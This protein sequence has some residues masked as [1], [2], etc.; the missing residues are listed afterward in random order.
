MFQLEEKR[1]NQNLFN[2][3]IHFFPSWK[4]ISS[5]ISLV[6]Q[7]S[8]GENTVPSL[9]STI[10]INF[11][12]FTWKILISSLYLQHLSWI[13]VIL[14]PPSETISM[15]LITLAKE[16]G[17]QLMR[18]IFFG[19]ISITMKIFINMIPS[20]NWLLTRINLIGQWK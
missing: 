18:E 17:F 2:F 3:L 6:H 13:R 7:L 16:I 4:S 9:L 12:Q 1:K 11:Y 5:S 8:P 15:V 10:I 20:W 14:L 19:F